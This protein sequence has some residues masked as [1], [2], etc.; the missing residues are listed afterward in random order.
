MIIKKKN[1]NKKIK[2]EVCLT[3]ENYQ[4]L[5]RYSK[6]KIDEIINES[7]RIYFDKEFCIREAERNAL[8]GVG[9]LDK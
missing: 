1:K 5:K 7:V 8:L 6:E 3:K 9:L 4:K 2:V